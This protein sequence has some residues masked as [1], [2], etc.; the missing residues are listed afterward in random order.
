[1]KWKQLRTKNYQFI[2]P[3][4]TDS[5]ARIYA[6]QFELNRSNT[7]KGIR[8]DPKPLPIILHPNLSRS[9]GMVIW[10]PK[11]VELMTMPPYD[12]SYP[13]PWAEQLALH[14]GRHVGQM[15]H[16]TKGIFRLLYYLIG[17]SS[18]GIGIGVTPSS[19]I[20]ESDAVMNE[21]TLSNAGRG[22]SG[23]FLQYYRASCLE[24]EGRLYDQ[25]RY[26]SYGRFTPNSYPFGY[27]INSY[28]TSTSD[29]FFSTGDLLNSFVKYALYFNYW[30]KSFRKATG[31]TDRESFNKSILSMGAEWKEDDAERAPFTP[32]TPLSSKC[33]QNYTVYS[34][35]IPTE[36][37]IYSVKAGYEHPRHLIKIYPNGSE[38]A[39]RPFPDYSSK[40]SPSS[41]GFYWSESIINPRWSLED[42][43][44]INFY[45]FKTGKT[46][47][48]TDRG[49]LFN[50]AVSGDGKFLS[51]TE[52]PVTGGSNLILMTTEGTVTDTVASPMHGQITETAWIGD[53][54]Y[55][56]EIVE[57]GEGIW[58][59]LQRNGKIS[60]GWKEEVAPQYQTM[61]SLVSD[62]KSLIFEFDLDGISNIYRYDPNSKVLTRIVDSRFGAFAPMFDATGKN[63]YYSVFDTKG[64]HPVS[65]AA[66]FLEEKASDFTKPYK[67]IVAEQ[68]AQQASKYIEKPSEEGKKQLKDSISNLE[69]VHYSKAGHLFHIHSWAP[70]YY[71]MDRF[72]EFSLPEWYRV[73]SP[74]AVVLSQNSLGTAT[75]MFGYSYHNHFHSGHFNFNY[76]GLYP[77]FDFTFDINDRNRT[78]V[79]YNRYYVPGGTVQNTDGM[80]TIDTLAHKPLIE[81]NMKV[82]IPLDLSS[83]GVNRTFAPYIQYSISNDTYFYHPEDPDSKGLPKQSLEYGIEF[84]L[85]T[86]KPKS[87]LYPKWGIGARLAAI[88]CIGDQEH[89]G[90]IGYGTFYLY[91]PG[92]W[93][94]HGFKATGTFQFQDNKLSYGYIDNLANMPRGYSTSM[95]SIRFAKVTADYAMPIYL[96]DA[97]ILSQYLMRL[98]VI[99]FGDLAL[100]SNRDIND[101]LLY[102]IGTDLLLDAHIFHI[103]WQFKFGVRCSFTKDFLTGKV[104]TPSFQFLV[105]TP[106]Y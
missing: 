94:S 38:K 66:C 41:E 37:G 32:F 86:P 64:Y 60:S 27:M 100:N 62:G 73:A 26:G 96:N 101:E 34:Q 57:N 70:V 9:N 7:M 98:Q 25:W 24:D 69:A 28:M 99:P 67:H 40:I 17:E 33:E 104:K 82:Y 58:S 106:M 103:G 52:Y 75:A 92:L 11:R 102:S 6:Y 15:D 12:G 39:I 63:L 88:S 79:R 1:M 29:N 30:S 89:N 68:I 23:T 85:M 55:A 77:A 71:N 19:W 53:R 14:E 44:V 95:A 97:Y 90:N 51:V 65:T 105:G 22:R 13:Q 80:F 72:S 47:R 78:A 91:M 16:Y 36:D 31:M 93:H 76:T 8:S 43:S 46:V 4:G 54:V 83:G 59:V 81:A 84:S 35:V 10:A 61:K 21:T 87:L 56:L 18:V 20:F 42:K 3:A 2:Y 74:G 50:P 48:L 5:L 45:D 49:H